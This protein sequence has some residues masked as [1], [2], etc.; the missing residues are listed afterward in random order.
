M[1]NNNEKGINPLLREVKIDTHENVSL[2]FE[3]AN[4]GSRF[5]A[6]LIDKAIR[7]TFY[8]LV[9]LS[10]FAVASMRK[11]IVDIISSSE[12]MIE[13]I[14]EYVFTGDAIS[15]IVKIATILLL[16]IFVVRFAYH[17]L[18]ELFM[19]GRTPGKVLCGT[20]VVSIHG[21]APTASMIFIRNILRVFHMIPGG[22]LIDGLLM[23]FSKKSQRIGDFAGKTMVIKT[24][25]DRKYKKSV[26][27]I[28]AKEL[29]F[30]N[31]A[32]PEKEE[33]IEEAWKK[34]MK[35]LL[36]NEQPAEN[37]EEESNALEDNSIEEKERAFLS[38]DEY[39]MLSSYLIERKE[40]IE[41][42]RYDKAFLSLIS[43]NSGKE[44]P[45]M[46][47]DEVLKYLKLC[48]ETLTKYYETETIGENHD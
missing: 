5:V 37:S 23:L 15:V 26:E 22:E 25:S 17:I 32:P 1:E 19:N 28:L 29:P 11:K 40:L 45:S 38:Y 7:I 46:S 43:K 34:E 41:C 33:D 16:V 6:D 48:N 44:Y 31:E 21:E 8:V 20:K 30:E 42:E 9:F 2:E 36:D 4:I 13:D 14:G 18:F 35:R 24:K 10:L 27:E 12:G 39:K 3:V 47:P